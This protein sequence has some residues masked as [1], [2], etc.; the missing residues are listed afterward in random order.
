MLQKNTAQHTSE[1][2]QQI[3][4]SPAIPY[5]ANRKPR[6]GVLKPS[7]LPSPINPFYNKKNR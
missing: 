1:Y 2:F 5:D 6:A 4:Q 3:R 7:P